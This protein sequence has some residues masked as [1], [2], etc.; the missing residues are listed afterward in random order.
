MSAGGVVAVHSTVH[1]HT[2]TRLQEEFRDLVFVDAPVSGGGLGA[3]AGDLVVMMGGPDAAV[4]RCR[5]VFE[6]YAGSMVHLGPLGFAEQAKLLNNALFTAQLGLVADVY[7][8]AE[9]R[10]MD[11]AALA[12]VL[13]DGSGRCFAAKFSATPPTG[14]SR[15]RRTPGRC[16]PRTS[17]SSL[18]C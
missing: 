15:W 16:W 5:P 9:R 6:T 8:L 4:E 1:P 12:T 3:A 17:T 18:R 10:G 2:M 14:S 13:G 7:A 11:L